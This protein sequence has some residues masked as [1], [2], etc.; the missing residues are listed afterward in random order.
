[1]KKDS[2]GGSEVG[3]DG[4]DQGEI[5]DGDSFDGSGSSM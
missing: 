5:F 1:V 4:D 2:Q 3:C